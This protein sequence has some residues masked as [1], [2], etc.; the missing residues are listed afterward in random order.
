MAGKYKPST[1]S[2]KPDRPGPPMT[3]PGNTRSFDMRPK[4][5]NDPRR[6]DPRDRAIRPADPGPDGGLDPDPGE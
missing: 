6:Q 2:I 4:P 3:T 5:N 1:P